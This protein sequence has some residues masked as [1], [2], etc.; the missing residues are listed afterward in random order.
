M[1]NNHAMMT[2]A[3]EQTPF[4]IGID[5]GGTKTEALLLAPDGAVLLR[6]RRATPLD[7]GYRA[8]LATVTTAVR[9]AMARVPA[10]APCTVGIGIPGS[11]DERTGLV[12]NANSTCLIGRP[13]QGDLEWELGRA[14]TLCN[15]ADCFT[16]AECR[17]GAG[18]GY[19]LVFGVIMGTG[20]GGGICIDGRVRPGPHRI[21]GEWGHL[22]VDPAG[23]VCYCGNRGCVETKISG[24]GVEAAFVREYG[25]RLSMERIVAGARTGEP[26]CRAAFDR[27]LDDF[28]RC[29]G[30]LISILDPD[31]V[32]LGGG[33][34]NIIE[35]YTTGIERVRHYAFHEHLATPILKNRL[36]DSAGVFGAA[37]IGV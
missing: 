28:G 37:W 1:T 7:Q 29:L 34:S 26:R 6:E 9:E 24:S 17:Q 22:S 32:V 36:G 33:L 2:S 20:C 35:L 4:R 19:G 3:S 12:R 27:F 10:G 14:V 13:L 23:A 11:S 16:L 21:A 8:V 5:L 31:A 18:L 25:E 30:G 15:D